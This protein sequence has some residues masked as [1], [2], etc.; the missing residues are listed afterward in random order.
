MIDYLPTFGFRDASGRRWRIRFD[1]AC[2]GRIFDV[3][4][5]TNSLVPGAVPD[6]VTIGFYLSTVA[7]AN[8]AIA[9]LQVAMAVMPQFEDGES[10]RR[11][12]ETMLPDGRVFTAARDALI[13]AYLS[14]W[15]QRSDSLYD[16]YAATFGREN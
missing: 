3:L 16:W 10:P 12:A 6:P 8:P 7:A 1:A 9:R 13:K 11:F 4:L 14:R 5:R 15:P 2:V